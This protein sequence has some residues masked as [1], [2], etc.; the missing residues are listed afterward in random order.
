MGAAN[1]RVGIDPRGGKDPNAPGVVWSPAIDP[2]DE[3]REIQVEAVALS[4][5]VTLFLYSHPAPCLLHNETFWDNNALFATG[6]AVAVPLEAPESAGAPA[7]PAPAEAAA[8]PES[9]PAGD[10]RP[11]PD[12]TSPSGS[13]LLRNAGFDD[14][15]YYRAPGL[16]V[17]EEW[18]LW[19]A[20][21]ET[22]KLDRQDVPFARPDSS[23]WSRRDAKR[24][25]EDRYFRSGNYCW[26]V[27]TEWKPAWVRLQQRVTGL[28]PGAAYRFTVPVLTEPWAVPEGHD[29]RLTSD[30][31]AAERRLWVETGEATADTGWLGGE[32]APYGEYER[33]SLDFTAEAEEATVALEMRGRWGLSLNQWVVDE[34]ELKRLG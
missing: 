30:P 19:Y 32:A 31:V 16:A 25:E 22:P 4:E 26:R 23:V 14:G 8:P 5:A 6:P 24:K 20:D 12:E 9:E 2:W 28:T 13:N 7:Q 18:E 10:G 33:L 34:M 15:Y 29:R 11:R 17:P 27:R 3:Y 21:G 1:L